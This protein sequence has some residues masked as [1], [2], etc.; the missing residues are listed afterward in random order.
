MK[1][2]QYVCW[3]LIGIGVAGLL[4]YALLEFFETPRC[5]HL[6]E[7]ISRD[8]HPGFCNTPGIC[9]HRSPPE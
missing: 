9:T 7:G 8:Y 5:S 2:W 6:V 4:V 3:I 1:L